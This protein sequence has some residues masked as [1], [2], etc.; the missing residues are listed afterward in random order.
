MKMTPAQNENHLIGI[1]K[2]AYAKG[3]KELVID[4]VKIS[5]ECFLQSGL[6]TGSVCRE[7]ID[8]GVRLPELGIGL[9]QGILKVPDEKLRKED[10]IVKKEAK[11]IYGKVLVDVVKQM[12]KEKKI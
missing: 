1:F 10:L 11:R 9:M 2:D 12:V 8:L 7:M 3:D 4:R 6:N 5:F